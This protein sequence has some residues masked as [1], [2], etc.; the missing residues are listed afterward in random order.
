MENLRRL[1]E[2]HQCGLVVEPGNVDALEKAITLLSADDERRT[3]MGARAR[4][5]A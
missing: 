3:A 4:V 1:I 5:D 2:Q